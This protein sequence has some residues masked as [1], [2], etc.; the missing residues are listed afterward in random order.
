MK[1]T[2]KDLIKSVIDNVHIMNRKKQKG[3]MFLFPELDYTPLTKTRA[4]RLVDS[5]LEIIKRSLERGQDFRLYGF[6]VFRTRFRWA[7]RGRDP[8]TGATI[9]IN[10]RR[11]VTFK[12][13]PRLVR[14]I[15]SGR[16]RT[17]K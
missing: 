9:I 7:R 5:T 17:A 13:S 6:G 3:Q 10:S 14:R 1:L 15:N 4:T 16:S 8:R 12:S 11:Y 2:K